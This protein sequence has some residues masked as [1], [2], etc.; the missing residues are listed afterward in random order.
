MLGQLTERKWSAK[1]VFLKK[2][3]AARE[4]VHTLF[5]FSPLSL[6]SNYDYDNDYGHPNQ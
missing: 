2:A 5:R 1:A 3:A 6:G 4:L